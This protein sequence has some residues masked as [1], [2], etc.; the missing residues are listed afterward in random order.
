MTLH[1]ID[2]LLTIQYRTYP[3]DRIQFA[4]VRHRSKH[5]CK[6]SLL[7]PPY[8]DRGDYRSLLQSPIYLNWF[9]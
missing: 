1:P 3:E 6:Q 2:S 8:R 9:G 7:L 4:S 5:G